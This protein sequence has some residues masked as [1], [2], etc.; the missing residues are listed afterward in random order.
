MITSKWLINQ[1]TPSKRFAVMW[2]EYMMLIA[3]ALNTAVE[4]TLDRIKKVASIFDQNA[5][6]LKITLAELGGEWGYGDITYENMPIIIMQRRDEYHFKS[7]TYPLVSTMLREFDGLNLT[8]QPLYASINSEYG[9]EFLTADRIEQFDLNMSD[10]FLTS[11]AYIR[12]PLNDIGSA[13]TDED[14]LAFEARLARV[15]YPLIPLHIVLD[16]TQYSLE[17]DLNDYTESTDYTAVT[18]QKFSIWDDIDY[19]DLTHIHVAQSPFIVADKY[20]SRVNAHLR[21]DTALDALPLDHDFADSI[22][23]YRADYTIFDKHVSV[24]L[25][26]PQLCAT[27]ELTDDRTPLYSRLRDDTALDAL[28]LD[29]HSNNKDDDNERDNDS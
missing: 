14:I 24:A 21:D 26:L 12:V 23:Q 27:I 16:G 9:T 22:T 2:R 19:I 8:W 1:L 11:R 28:P 13:H 3:D 17:F 4:P 7:T 5:I 6:D 29:Y 25:Q 15:I 20:R 18:H 10:F